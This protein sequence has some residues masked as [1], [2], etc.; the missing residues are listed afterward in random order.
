MC[1][2]FPTDPA[3]RKAVHAQLT[4]QAPELMADLA[5]L[6]EHFPTTRLVYVKTEQ[7]LEYGKRPEPPGFVVKLPAVDLEE[8]RRLLA[9]AERKR[10]GK[11]K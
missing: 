11:K 10:K 9:E 1:K 4:A 7:G 8:Q 3:G 2:P 6:R 5:L